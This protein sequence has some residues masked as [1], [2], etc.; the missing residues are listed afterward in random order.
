M[1][2]FALNKNHKNILKH[3]QYEESSIFYGCCPDGFGSKCTD[4][5]VPVD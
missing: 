2:I 3:I 4:H 1:C 5:H